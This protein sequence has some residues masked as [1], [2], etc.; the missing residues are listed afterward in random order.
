[1]IGKTVVLVKPDAVGKKVAG[2]VITRFEREGLKIVAMKMIFF[3]KEKAEEFYKVHR[4]KHFFPGLIRFMT[5]CPSVAMIVEGEN[6]VLRV[7]EIIGER[8]PHEASEGTIRRD[9]ASDGRRNIV[10]GSDSP[11]TAKKEMACLFSPQE[12]YSYNEKDW[13][14]SEP[15]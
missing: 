6:A 8:V 12:V 15:G 3:D 5:R 4:E 7:R 14:D 9:L 11:E 1:M 2:E 10:H 13:L